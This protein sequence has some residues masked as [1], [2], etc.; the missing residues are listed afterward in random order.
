VSL[1]VGW[2]PKYL[3]H[4]RTQIVRVT[5]SKAP[6]LTAIQ[7]V[8]AQD[9][10]V[11][12][13]GKSHQKPKKSS[14]GPGYTHAK[15]HDT[16][17]LAPLSDMHSGRPLSAMD[18]WDMLFSFGCFQAIIEIVASGW[19]APRHHRINGHR[20]KEC[21]WH[22][23]LT[24]FGFPWKYNWSRRFLQMDPKHDDKAIRVL[25]CH[26]FASPWPGESGKSQEL[27]NATLEL[28][29]PLSYSLV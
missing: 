15:N 25:S 22:A 18:F 13:V 16:A 29:K 6:P 14:D 24:H 19:S 10:A 12:C 27:F 9:S 2:T 11:K 4:L 17:C 21:T 1:L 8:Q 7:G 3:G 5:K 23:H 26:R 20:A 28:S